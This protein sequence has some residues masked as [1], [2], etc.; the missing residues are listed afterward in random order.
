MA[1]GS[2]HTNFQSGFPF[3]TGVALPVTPEQ[4]FRNALANPSV[5]K[6]YGN[7][8]TVAVSASDLSIMVGAQGVPVGIVS[9]SWPVAK[10]LANKILDVVKQF[11]GATKMQIADVDQIEVGRR[12]S[13]RV[14]FALQVPDLD[15]ALERLAAKGAKLIHPPVETPWGDRNARIEDPDGMQITLYQGTSS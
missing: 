13:G 14:R 9:L 11:E 5:P 7:G 12:V 15:A 6:V 3:S 4:A 8:F 1:G 2:Q 10:A